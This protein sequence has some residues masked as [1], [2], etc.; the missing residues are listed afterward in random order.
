VSPET[1]PATFSLDGLLSPEMGFDVQAAFESAASDVLNDDL[2]ELE[3]KIART[4]FIL[5][6]ASSEIYREL[7]DLSTLAEQIMGCTH[8]HA[9]QG[10]LL[11]GALGDLFGEHAGHDHA[12]HTDDEKKPDTK[13]SS[14][15][16]QTYS[17][18]I[19]QFFRKKSPQVRGGKY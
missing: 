12:H 11:S 2:L 18:L 13:K 7:V 5:Q 19:L 8:D 17:Q 9:V 1:A 10:A 4:E 6:E 3:E 15:P 14:K 16:R